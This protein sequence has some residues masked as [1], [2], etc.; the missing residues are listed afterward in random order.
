[1]PKC[2]RCSEEFPEDELLRCS[3][4]KKYYCS[5]CAK[6]DPTIETLG[7]CSDC[8]EVFTDEEE[9]WEGE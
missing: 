3:D 7:V 8:E 4:C 1:M 2:A 9:E 5:K 6:K